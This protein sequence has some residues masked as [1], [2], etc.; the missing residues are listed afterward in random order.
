MIYKLQELPV[1]RWIKSKALV[2][3]ERGLFLLANED[4][5]G[6]FT[7]LPCVAY[8]SPPTEVHSKTIRVKNKKR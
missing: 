7:L 6:D 2:T 1:H 8:P 3:I 5:I 4:V